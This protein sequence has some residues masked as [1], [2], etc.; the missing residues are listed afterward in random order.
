MDLKNLKIK[1]E[2][3]GIKTRARLK[4]LVTVVGISLV[5]IG[6]YNMLV[7][8]TTGGARIALVGPLRVVGSEGD[9]LFLL[10]DVV[11]MAAGGVLAWFF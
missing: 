9:G 1:A 4:L 7:V 10:G 2:V 3:V 5:L 11:L 8:P 6:A